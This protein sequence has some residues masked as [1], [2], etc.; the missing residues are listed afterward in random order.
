MFS[1]E[2]AFAIHWPQEFVIEYCDGTCERLLHG[3]GVMIIPPGDDPD[4][5]GAICADLPKKHPRNQKQCG[6]FIRFTEIRAVYAAEGQRLW[7]DA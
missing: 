7:P 1:V 5:I 6:R 2:V 4:G 3:D